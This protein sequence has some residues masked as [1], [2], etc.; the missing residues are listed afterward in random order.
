MSEQ[1]QSDSHQSINAQD[2]SIE[3]SN[4]GQVIGGNLTQIQGEVVNV[5][6]YDNVDVLGL[7][8]RQTSGSVKPLTQQDYR[9]RKVLLNKVKKFW[10]EGVLEKSLH[11][12]ALIE[13]GLEERLDAVERPFQDVQEIP[14]ESRQTLPSA[15]DATQVFNQMGEGR[16]LLILG[17]PGAGKTTILLKLAHNLIAR[18]EED[19][20]QP[21]P[22]VFNLSSWASERQTI[23]DWLVGELNRKYQVSK[24]LGKAW[25]EEQ[26]LLLLLDGLDEVKAERREACVQALNQF[27]Q[28]HGQTEMVV[29]SRIRDYEALSVRLKLQGAICIQSLTPE[30]INQYLERAG[31]QLEAVKTL[32]QEDTAL[33]ELTKSPLTLSVMTLAYQGISVE[34]LPKTGS[35]EGRRQHLFNAYIERM[36][37][38]KGANQQYSKAQAMCWLTWL[39]QRMS[40]ESQTVFLIERMQPSLLKTKVQL[41]NY[42]IVILLIVELIPCLFFAMSSGIFVGIFYRINAVIDGF[43]WGLYFSIPWLIL[44]TLILIIRNFFASEI[45]LFESFIWSWKK[46]IIG[47][48]KGFYTG[49]FFGAILTILGM[50]FSPPMTIY[51]TI[52]PI[53]IIISEFIWGVIF[54]G[55]FFGIIFGL[56]FGCILGWNNNFQIEVTT[57]P[58]YGIWKSA[59]NG[60]IIGLLTSLINGAIFGLISLVVFRASWSNDVYFINFLMITGLIF[61]LIFG[62]I[63]SGGKPCI[64]HFTL[65]LILYR[66]GFVPWNY[67]HFLDYATERIFLQKVGSGYIFIHRLLLEHF[68]QMELEQVRR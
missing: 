65:R 52:K 2:T 18:T 16:T 3:K 1:P 9:N 21:I 68:A 14:D 30:Q 15:T 60:G 25:V 47:L 51:G 35:V 45:K 41:I 13:L 31:D 37:K 53:D 26:Q 56:T 5:T 22:V 48:L 61:G 50:L 42:K 54:F 4:V 49:F 8:R 46:G 43:I 24:K 57:I 44:G 20:S 12:K 66:N 62:L 59:I 6:V 36:F 10:I 63:N 55:L 32:L 33:Q 23:A 39:A 19:L 7:G 64:Q 11:I 27:I 40:Q 34:D 17:E 67:A 58:N 38:R 29:C 28:E